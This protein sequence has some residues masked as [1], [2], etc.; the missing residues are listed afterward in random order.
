MKIF[1]RFSAPSAGPAQLAIL[2]L[3]AWSVL[4]GS[5][6]QTPIT[7]NL[8]ALQASEKV[9]FVCRGDDNPAVGHSID[10]CPD[11][12]D[13]VTRRMLSLVTQTATNEVAI[14]DLAAQLI[15]DVDPSTPGYSFL[16]V[17][18]RPGAIV[19]TPGGAANFVGVS[20][21][22]KNGL[23]A[24]PTTCMGPPAVGEPARDL[25]TWS[26]CHL[27]S[28]PGDITVVIDPTQLDD[29]SQR[30]TCDPTDQ[31]AA[32]E[33]EVELAQLGRTCPADVTHEKGPKGRRKLLVA[34]P[35]EHKLVLVDAQELLDRPA[36][37]FGECKTTEYKLDAALP[38]TP[39]AERLPDVLKPVP[40][41]SS[42]ACV[43][44]PYPHQDTP[45]QT[46]GGMANAGDIVYLADRTAPVVHRIDVSDPCALKEQDPL[47]PTSFLTPQRT[48]TT[49]RVA[50]SPLT[51]KGQQFVYAVD[52]SDQP[53]AS[54]MVFDVSPGSTER[55]P[56]VFPEAIR[57]PYL[58]PD[59][60]Q[61]GAD[62]RDVSFVMR[63]FPTPDP[64][65]GVGQFGLECSPLLK[66]NGTPSAS[67]RPNTVDPTTGSS[68]PLNL[69]GV[70]A[71]AML[72]NGQIA[73]IDVEDFD[74]PCRRPEY[75]N[76]SPHPD[77]RG[78]SGDPVQADPQLYTLPA[79]VGAKQTEL[80]SPTVTNESSCNVIEPNRPR[81]Q[82]L[83]IS[84]P[85]VGLQAPTL[86]AFPQFVNPDPS[87]VLQPEQQPHMLAVN[88][89]NPDPMV[90]A[91]IPAQV[92]VSSQQYKACDAG[93]VSSI[94]GLDCLGLD[95]ALTV[96][97]SLTLPLVEPRSYAAQ[98]LVG[99]TFEGRL[100]PKIGAAGGVSPVG[101]RQ[102]G[103]L[104]TA[105]NGTTTLSDPDAS[106]CSY[107]V[108]DAQAIAV[109]AER[110]GIPGTNDNWNSAH[111]D[112]VQ[113]TG[114]FPIDYDSYWTVGFGASCKTTLNDTISANSHDACEAMFGGIDDSATLYPSRD[115][116]ISGA[117]SDH[118]EV[119][120]RDC[121]P[122]GDCAARMNQI[123]CCFPSGTLYNVR[124]SKQWLLRGTSG[125]HD[126]A[127]DSNLHCVHTASCDRRKQLYRS[128][129]FEVCTEGDKDEDGTCQTGN[130]NVACAIPAPASNANPVEPNGPGSACIFEGLTSRFVVYRGSKRS[131]RDMVF[132][133]QTVGGFTPLAMSLASQTFAVN[134]QSINFV[135]QLNAL[136]VVDGTTLG[137]TVFDLDLLGVSLPSPYY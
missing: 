76:S 15:V 59:R 4:L 70:F 42:D 47:L 71:F 104:T 125:L 117:F 127:A 105:P 84:S 82:S 111:A 53:S 60:L 14:I 56:Q 87:T 58:P 106:F 39:P 132:T 112:Y 31:D 38:A 29:G 81:S 72:T 75:V 97:N 98:E 129:A 51:P 123:R 83:S 32:P 21:L 54:L 126:M 92:F 11:R 124:A 33:T 36:G 37:Q 17:G 137:L 90:R 40:G 113:L 16:R 46:P 85:T 88:F 69:R 67:Y 114:D 99:L 66:D 61:F 6:S 100:L 50:V 95:P 118:L 79:V 55:T 48:V 103:F 109:E 115:L 23:F 73:V 12:N 22:G 110:A 121:G 134:P 130:Q 20:G 119:K 9:T 68:R 7:V 133:W 5:C 62:V 96:R 101:D 27:S 25:T 30:V 93:T 63:D 120:P 64:I 94:D 102:S 10:E 49:T 128:R 43:V 122:D 74:A 45:V 91:S 13:V 19:T 35:D 77:F 131:L 135:P 26:A 89:P 24:L 28:A 3:L 80:D 116:T 86:S 8:H 2:A 44:A 136:T 107:G 78:C 41:A 1:S 18:G 52:E 108:E 57:N 65:T 34:L